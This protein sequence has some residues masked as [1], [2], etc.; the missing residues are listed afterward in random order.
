M[1]ASY[2]LVPGSAVAAVTPQNL[3][4][5]AP[6]FRLITGV[7]VIATGEGSGTA[8]TIVNPVIATVK[9]VTALPTS[10]VG[11]TEFDY[12]VVTGQWQYGSA[13]GPQTN[14]DVWFEITGLLQ[15][16]VPSMS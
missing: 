10:G 5:D 2:T 13:C 16:E 4:A 15:G 6:P 7:K 8:A 12:N 11:A 9:N 14:G 1:P 3:P